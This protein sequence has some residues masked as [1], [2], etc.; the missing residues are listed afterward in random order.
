MRKG[1]GRVTKFGKEVA[2]EMG[3]ELMEVVKRAE[4]REKFIRFLDFCVP[5]LNK[6]QP[7][8]AIWNEWIQAAG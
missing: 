1:V 4:D 3:E 2:M 6:D 5:R 7:V 8:L